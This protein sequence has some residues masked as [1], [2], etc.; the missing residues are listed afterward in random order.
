MKDKLEKLIIGNSIE[1]FNAI[2]YFESFRLE[3]LK[4][5]DQFYIKHMIKYIKYLEF[6]INI[7]NEAIKNMEINE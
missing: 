3:E 7:K 6:K 5:D 1:T 2:E 4:E